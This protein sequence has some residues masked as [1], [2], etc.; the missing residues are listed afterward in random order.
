M[1][2]Q[3]MEELEGGGGVWDRDSE[4]V[5]MM[6]VKK[7]KREEAIIFEFEK[8]DLRKREKVVCV[9]IYI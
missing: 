4:M 2:L 6:I 7:M 1:P 3:R 5:E 9:Y 8:S